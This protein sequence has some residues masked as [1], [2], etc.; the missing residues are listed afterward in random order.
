MQMAQLTSEERVALEEV[1]RLAVALK[2][3]NTTLI[4]KKLA[5]ASKRLE[6]LRRSRAGSSK[7]K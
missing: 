3:G 4:D 1:K 7:R 2:E 6:S 5:D